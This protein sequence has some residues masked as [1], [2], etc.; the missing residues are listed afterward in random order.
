MRK[1]AA[2]LCVVALLAGAANAAD[3]V[4]GVNFCSG[5]AGPQVPAGATADGF[6]NWTNS[7]PVT[8][9]EYSDGASAN[10]TGLV[11]LGSGN[12]VTVDWASNNIWY[13]GPEDNPENSLYRCYLDD[14][15]N[16]ALITIKGLNSWLASVGATAYKVRIYQNTDW[17]I[18]NKDGTFSPINFLSTNITDGT[19]VLQTVQPTNEWLTETPTW[20][21]GIDRGTR[22]FVNS[23]SLT[24]DTLVIDGA[25]GPSGGQRGGISAVKIFAVPEP[26]TMILLGLGSL[27][28][29]R[30]R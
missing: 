18:D 20:W 14:G 24:V 23:A 11:L 12:G 25:A 7:M 26:A 19:N 22:G 13:A 30:K 1:L 21:G 5:W 16:G 29:R 27:L 10:G 3:S 6:S 2:V 17:S 9:N 8:G 28:L 15:G 4:L